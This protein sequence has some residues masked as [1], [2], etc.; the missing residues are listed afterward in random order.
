MSSQLGGSGLGDLSCF[1][2]T[3]DLGTNAGVNE[4]RTSIREAL[5]GESRSEPDDGFSRL[6][7]VLF[8]VIRYIIVPNSSVQ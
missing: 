6:A 7:V 8:N 4:G 2:N 5:N 3:K 1:A